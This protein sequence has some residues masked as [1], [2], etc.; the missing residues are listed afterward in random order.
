MGLCVIFMECH[1]HFPRLSALRAVA[2]AVSI[3]SEPLSVFGADTAL[4]WSVYFKP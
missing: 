3:L 1:F 4:A 2:L